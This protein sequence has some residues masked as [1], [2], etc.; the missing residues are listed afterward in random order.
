MDLFIK[1]RVEFILKDRDG[2]SAL[3]KKRVYLVGL[4]ILV[5]VIILL[6]RIFF[7][8]VIQ[9]THYTTL[10]KTNRQ[11]ILPIAPIRGLIYSSDGVIL[12][13]NK[14]TYSLEVIP[15]KIPDIDQLI[16][17][18]REIIYIDE[19]DVERFKKL[20]NKKRRFERV[21]LRIN[22]NENEV[23]LFSINRHLFSSV[24]VVEG[25]KRHYPLGREFVHSVGYVSRIDESDL[26]NISKLVK[27]PSE[28]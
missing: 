28:L 10:S 14:P 7:L 26:K 23:A 12:A 25:F 19:K 6:A 9:N 11:K 13:E 17:K 4:I 5:L 18:L 1:D 22:L 27:F 24:D 20:A 2:E 16:S 8:T 3:I 15:E 21:P